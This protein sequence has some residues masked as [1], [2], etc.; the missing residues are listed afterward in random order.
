LLTVGDRA[1]LWKEGTMNT[2]NF[3]GQS[4]IKIVKSAICEEK[5][6]IPVDE[7]IDDRY[8]LLSLY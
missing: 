5:R 2:T 6:K 1:E 7:I 4:G 3:T 8:V